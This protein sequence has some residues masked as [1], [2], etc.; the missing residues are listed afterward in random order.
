V[1]ARVYLGRRELTVVGVVPDLMAGDIQDA[2][3]DGLY[4]SIWQLRPFAVRI[5]A[6]GAGDPFDLVSLLR[7]ETARIDPDLTLFETF[8]LRDAATARA[9]R[10]GASADPA[11]ARRRAAPRRSATPRDS[12][13]TRP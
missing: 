2:R 10:A 1:G 8:T 6:R 4:A 9:R 7:R 13:L 3:Q 5:V 12:P 11:A